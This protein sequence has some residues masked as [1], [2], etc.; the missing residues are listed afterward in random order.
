MTRTM[1]DRILLGLALCLFAAATAISAP[2]PQPPQS[3]P[4]KQPA[5]YTYVS[6][7]GVP[8]ANWGEYEKSEEKSNK[9]FQSLVTD[10]TLVSWGSA[11]VE[12][13]E[14]N[15]APNYVSWFSSTSIAG[16]LKALESVRTNAPPAANI[17]YTMHADE[18]TM[19]RNYNMKGGAA[20][21]YLV[22]QN[23]KVKMGH[24]DDMDELFNKH[25]KAGLDAMVADGTINGYSM[26][27][28]LIHTGPPG[29][30]SLVVEFPNAE[31]IDKFY[32]SIDSLH[33]KDPLFGVAFSGVQEPSE[34]R[35]HLLRVIN[36]G[37]K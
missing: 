17:N 23:W 18:L 27:E 2:K 24:G 33:E 21:K 22:V 30:V 6:L 36:S 4:E 28:D 1:C 5:I 16:I 20:A 34:H 32:A 31:S 13:H 26:E 11:A 29:F 19:S 15:D 14:G 9:N 37:H 12:V 8:R 10:G 3:M 7:F 25:R 35:D